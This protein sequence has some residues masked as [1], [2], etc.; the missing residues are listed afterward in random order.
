MTLLFERISAILFLLIAGLISWRSPLTLVR[1]LTWVPKRFLDRL[2]MKNDRYDLLDEPEKY[3]VLYKRQLESIR[4]SGIMALAM[5]AV[6]LCMFI[7][8]FSAR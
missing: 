5:A 2:S 8:S 1:I 6:L 7:A 3:A 4:L